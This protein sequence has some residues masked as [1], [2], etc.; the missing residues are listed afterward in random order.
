MDIHI[1]LIGIHDLIMDTHNWIVDIHYQFMDIH[2][3]IMDIHNWLWISITMGFV[4]F[5][6]P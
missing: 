1:W 6:I 4:P 2:Q 5:G 3:S